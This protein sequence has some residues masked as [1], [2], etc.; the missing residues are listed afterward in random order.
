MRVIFM[1]VLE[2]EVVEK[3]FQLYLSE[4]KRII[5]SELALFVS[6]IHE[7]RLHTQIEY[8]LLSQG[9]RLRPILTILC[10]QSVGG[11][12]ARVMPLALSFELLHTATLIHDDIIDGDEI[13]R[14]IPTLYKKWDANSAILTG[15]ILISLAINLAADFGADIMKIASESGLDLSDGE[16]MDTTTT[17]NSATEEEYFLK[18][19]KKS[20]SLFK[21][22]AQCGALG[23]GGSRLESESLAL[24]GEYV[25]IAYQLR[26]D[27]QDLTVSRSVPKDLRTGR[28]TLPLIHLYKVSGPSKRGVLENDL[29]ILRTENCN[30]KNII[31]ERIL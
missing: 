7:L 5:N 14:G 23:G 10:A 26:D 22:A 28:V 29:Q 24:F 30:V 18:I 13:R 17:L 27:I 20:A 15:D 8:A 12:R 25:G 31:L 9:K 19:R 1:H 2:K 4:T 6:R 16:Y 11:D 21:A 3:D